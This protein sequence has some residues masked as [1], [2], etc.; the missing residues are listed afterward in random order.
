LAAILEEIAAGAEAKGK[1]RDN[2]LY[3]VHR[4]DEAIR[5]AISLASSSDDAVVLLGKGHEK[6][7]ERADGVYGFFTCGFKLQ[8]AVYG[9][10]NS[11]AKAC[12][13][14]NG[15]A[16][17]FISHIYILLKRG[18]V[19]QDLRGYTGICP[20]ALAFPANICAQTVW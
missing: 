18:G 7:I 19:L 16:L 11:G 3:I 4:R 12:T 2:T 10:F 1:I 8:N 17:V 15:Y 13:R 9:F 20:F 5:K 14:G 6:T